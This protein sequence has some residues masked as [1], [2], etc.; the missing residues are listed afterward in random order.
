[1]RAAG[2]CSLTGDLLKSDFENGPC[3]KGK[4]CD[5]QSL[6]PAQP[7]F[8]REPQLEVPYYATGGT[9][10]KFIPYLDLSVEA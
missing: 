2:L 5:L 7:A 6:W 8:Y 4:T 9:S 10:A 3:G 1:M